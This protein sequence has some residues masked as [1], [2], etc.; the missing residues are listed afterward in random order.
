MYIFTN[1]RKY[2]LQKSLGASARKGIDIPMKRFFQK[3]DAETL[4]L[5][6]LCAALFAA[7]AILFAATMA[8]LRSPAAVD[9]AGMGDNTIIDYTANEKTSQENKGYVRGNSENIQNSAVYYIVRSH[10]DRIAVFQ[11][12]SDTP[13]YTVDTP[14]THLPESDRLLLEEGIPAESIADAYRIIE[15]YE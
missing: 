5:Y 14:L 11:N 8:A 1:T 6:T 4:R 7:A 13:L 15:D 2:Y 12:G 3:P 10:E 9:A